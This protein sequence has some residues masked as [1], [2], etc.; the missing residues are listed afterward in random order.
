MELPQESFTYSG[1][2][3][4]EPFLMESHSL[5]S[6]VKVDGNPA[7]YFS[8]DDRKNMQKAVSHSTASGNAA[9]D[10]NILVGASFSTG[11]VGTPGTTTASFEASHAAANASETNFVNDK[12]VRYSKTVTTTASKYKGD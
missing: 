1:D 5:T 4:A 2:N 10:K 9:G 3:D 8:G 7:D 11:S 6:L 12:V